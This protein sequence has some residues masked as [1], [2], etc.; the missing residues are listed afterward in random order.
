MSGLIQNLKSTY[1]HKIRNLLVTKIIISYRSKYIGA[2]SRENQGKG[3][4]KGQQVR[5][6]LGL[7]L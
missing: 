3:A 6:L 4:V 7:A 1:L 5:V 2:L